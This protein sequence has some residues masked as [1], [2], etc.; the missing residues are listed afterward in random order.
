MFFLFIFT[1]HSYQDVVDNSYFVAASSAIMT[2][3]YQ[4]LLSLVLLK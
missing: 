1:V 3:S 4:L 2:P